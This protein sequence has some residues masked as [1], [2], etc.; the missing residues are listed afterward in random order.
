[1]LYHLR[2]PQLSTIKRREAIK[3]LLVKL[4]GAFLAFSLVLALGA[5]QKEEKSLGEKLDDGLEEAGESI[6]EGVDE[7]GDGI[8]EA[9]E[10]TEDAIE[11]AVD[12]DGH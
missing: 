5:C 12:G 2:I 6:E 3:N 1:M 11:D 4:S 9:V 7:I 8:E 10:D